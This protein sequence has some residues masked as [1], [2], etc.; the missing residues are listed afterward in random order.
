MASINLVQFVGE[1]T[2]FGLTIRMGTALGFETKVAAQGGSR[3]VMDL[4]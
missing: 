4:A 1:K 3:Q 2:D